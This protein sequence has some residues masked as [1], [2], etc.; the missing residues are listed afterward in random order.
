MEREE[1][2]ERIK[3]EMVNEEGLFTAQEEAIIHRDLWS[4]ISALEQTSTEKLLAIYEELMQRKPKKN[5][6]SQ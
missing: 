1:L 4:Y 2:I 3:F 6:F 5:K